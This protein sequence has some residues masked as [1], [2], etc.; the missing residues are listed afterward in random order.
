[1]IEKFIYQGETFHSEQAV[2]NAIMSKEKKIFGKSPQVDIAAFWEKHGV[3]YLK[4]EEPLGNFKSLKAMVVK[5]TFLNWRA[6][7]A[8]LMSSLGFKADSNE[9]AYADVSGLLISN[10]EVPN[11][12]ITF[13]DA[14][15]QFHQLSYSQ[16]KTLQRE[17]IENGNFAY[18]Q[19][20]EFD[21]QVSS[22]KSKEELDAIDVTFVGMNFLKE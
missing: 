3:T 4:V 19:K 11:A 12:V 8:T 1:M 6:N 22:A 15:N 21:S 20:W 13:R 9:R 10:E 14:D 5:Q 2:R 16:L 17:I 7:K 18:A